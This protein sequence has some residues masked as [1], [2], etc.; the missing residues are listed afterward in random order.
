MSSKARGLVDKGIDKAEPA[1]LKALDGIRN[2]KEEIRAKLSCPF[3]IFGDSGGETGQAPKVSWQEPAGATED[4]LR[5]DALEISA[6][7]VEEPDEI[8]DS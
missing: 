3:G 4:R 7:P 1:G 8:F 5:I 6:L 2:I